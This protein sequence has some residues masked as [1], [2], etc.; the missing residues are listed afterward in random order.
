MSDLSTR[1]L[2]AYQ[3][4]NAR[5]EASYHAQAEERAQHDR[6]R[7]MQDLRL[8]L[9][10]V[11]DLDLEVTEPTIHIE[12]LIFRA[13]GPHKLRLV[14]RCDFCGATIDSHPFDSLEALGYVLDRG[15][16]YETEHQ[17]PPSPR[18]AVARREPIGELTFVQITVGHSTLG[19]EGPVS[20]AL[21]GLTAAGKVY[22][23]DDYRDEGWDAVSMAD[24]TSASPASVK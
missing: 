9:P 13:Y 2:A 24:V 19:P 7:E 15:V 14:D 11:L 22:R 3:A 16:A 8:A 4:E 21:Y 12:G 23:Y 1:A 20:T 6:A 5:Q 10:Q 18:Q 17:C